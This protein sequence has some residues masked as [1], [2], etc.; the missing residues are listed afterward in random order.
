[1]KKILLLLAVSFAATAPLAAANGDNNGNTEAGTATY[2]PASNDDSV[3]KAKKGPWDRKRYFNIGYTMQ[4]LS[5]EYGGYDLDSKLGA[6]LVIGRNY[7]L[8]RKPIANMLKFAIDF[9]SDINYAQYKDTAGNY[10]NVGDGGYGDG[11]DGGNGSDV[12]YGDR[13]DYGY[14]YDYNNDYGYEEEEEESETGLHHLDLGLHVGTS[15]SINPVDH[16][17][18]SAFFR[19][20]P[21]YSIMLLD[22]EFYHGF[23]PM[24]TYGG[25]I[26]YKVIG[27]GIEGR[28][29]KPKYSYIGDSEGSEKMPCNISALRLYISFRF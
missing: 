18:L 10:G 7:F 2:A 22:G 3:V 14:S 21:S 12:G 19:F 6:S 23:A 28:S 11:G 13:N 26:S 17:K 20:A 29:G 15:L 1:M 4:T 16:L 9:G 27:V 24:F 5:P 8:H 25:E